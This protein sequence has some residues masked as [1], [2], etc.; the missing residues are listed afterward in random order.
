MLKLG[1]PH[2][3]IGFVHVLKGEFEPGSSRSLLHIS[4]S[5]QDSALLAMGSQNNEK[6]RVEEKQTTITKSNNNIISCEVTVK[7]YGGSNLPQIEI[8]GH[9]ANLCFVRYQFLRHTSYML[10]SN[11]STGN[12]L[13]RQLCSAFSKRQQQFT[14]IGQLKLIELLQRT[15]YQAHIFICRPPMKEPVVLVFIFQL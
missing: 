13:P 5:H 6:F 2:S 12:K 1:L 10:C 7:H 14:I 8:N 11:K 9:F 4:L 3:P 15:E